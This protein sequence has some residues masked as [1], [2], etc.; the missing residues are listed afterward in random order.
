[1]ALKD[2]VIDQNAL[3]EELIENL[4]SSYVR[5]DVNQK[6]IVFLPEKMQELAIPH[7]IVIF[8]LALRGW[9]YFENATD[10]PQ[11]AQPKDISIAIMEN[12]STTRTYLQVLLKKGL[13]KKVSAKYS[14]LPTT[15][16]KI[17]NYLQNEK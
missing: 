8:L 5:Y 4:V 9:E 6:V 12:G 2:L 1:M 3:N 13:V 7:K 10:I 15:I 14:V 17:Q 16:N 11:D